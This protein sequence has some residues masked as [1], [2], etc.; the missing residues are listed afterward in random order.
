[1][2]KGF[3]NDVCNSID[4]IVTTEIP[5]AVLQRSQD[6]DRNIPI[7]SQPYPTV[8]ELPL[9]SAFCRLRL[10]AHR[11][12]FTCW[13]GECLT[14][15]MAYPRQLARKTYVT[16][17][18]PDPDVTDDLVP[19]RRYATDRNGDEKISDPP[20]PIFTSPVDTPDDRSL[21]S[22]LRRTSEIEQNQS[23]SN[24]LTT[25]LL[26]C[27]TS[28]QPTIAPTQARNAVFYSSKYCSKNPYKLSSTLSFLYTAQL[29]LRNYGSVADDVGS[30]TRTTKCL[31]QKGLHK[32]GRLLINRQLLQTLAMT[33][34]FLVTSFA[35]FLSGMLS[36]D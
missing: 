32:A 22:G 35:M 5:D 2:I 10:N 28:I 7:A 23:E 15:R 34:T 24:P 12:C 17:I 13:K 18:I 1:M 8:E 14:C 27:N 30:P 25:A 11:H 33:H 36:K 16:E 29:A 26:R 3:R 4:A 19:I 20:S 31:M 9:D 6:F 21:V